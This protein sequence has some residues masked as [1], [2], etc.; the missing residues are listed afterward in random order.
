MAKKRDPVDDQTYKECVDIYFKFY[1]RLTGLKP[2]YDGIAGKSMKKLIEYMQTN[3]KDGFTVQDFLNTVLDNYNLWEPFY[4]KQ[5]KVNQILSNITNI[6]ICIRNATTRNI[7]N[8][9]PNEYRTRKERIR[10][11]TGGVGSET[12]IQKSRSKE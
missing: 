7:N 4:Q 8:S 10:Q 6:I 12:G 9:K 2:L 5:L 3:L 11:R 1:E